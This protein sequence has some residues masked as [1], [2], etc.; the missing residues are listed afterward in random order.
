MT[1][2]RTVKTAVLCTLKEVVFGIGDVLVML[3]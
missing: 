1:N 3:G 2:V